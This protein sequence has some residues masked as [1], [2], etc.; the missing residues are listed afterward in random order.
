MSVSL[1]VALIGAK[2]MLADAVQRLAPGNWDIR[3]YD[4]PGFDLTDRTSV[5]DLAGENPDLIINCAALTDVDGCESRVEQ[6]EAVNGR[7]PGY[8]AELARCCGATLVHISTDFVFD[9]KKDSPYLETDTPD[10]L[11]VYGLSKL[12]GEQAILAVGLGSCF[13]IRT[14]WLYGAGGGNFVETM[15]RLARERESLGIVADQTGT[16]TW[17]DDL[18]RAMLRLLE[19]GDYGIYHYSNDGA[20]SWYDFACAAIELARRDE[21]L[22]VRQVRPITT[23][24]YPLPACRPRYSVLSKQKIGKISGVEIPAWRESLKRY[25]EQRQGGDKPHGY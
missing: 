3:G 7:G 8:L 21:K 6:A 18:V 2:G 25:F 20:C 15:V 9:G 23:A 1:K 10:P 14:S 12:H 13:I 4:L 19:Q 16:P 22:A 11:S 5:L 24:D 17:T